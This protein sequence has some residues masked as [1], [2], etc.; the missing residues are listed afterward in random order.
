MNSAETLGEQAI[1]LLG[2]LV[3][4]ACVNNGEP[5]SGQEIRNADVLSRFFAGSGVIPE[6]VE[7][8]PGRASLVVRIP[9]TLPGALSLAL[10][11][12]I[13]VVPALAAD[14]TVDPF[15]AE[16]IDDVLFGRGSLDM[17]YLTA[18]YAVLARALAVES[19]RPNGTRLRGDLIFAAVADEEAGSRLGVEWL[20]AN[21]PDL[22]DADYVLT[23][24]GGVPVGG[25]AALGSE[26]PRQVSAVTVTVGEKG[27]ARRRLVVH[28]V[29]G[30]GSAP[31]GSRNAAVLAA[32]AVIRIT[33]FAPPVEI[34]D[35]W[36]RYVHALGLP[37]DLGARLIAPN[38]FEVALAELGDLAGYAHAATHT[39]LSPNVVRGG[40]AINVI[41]GLATVDL[42][43]RILPGVSVQDVD[44]YLRDA[45]GELVEHIE[46]TGTAFS[47]ANVS[48]MDNDL[49]EV[50]SEVIGETYPGARAL[51]IIAAGGS[52]ARF[53]RARG[54]TAF[55]FSMLSE[56]WTYGMFRTLIHSNDE[57]IDLPSVRLTV[58]TLERVVRRLL[59]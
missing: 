58:E 43:V 15:S 17:L 36:P 18:S 45:L 29:P 47:P 26:E 24:S 54:R 9:G 34:G 42:D 1:A 37:A 8:H 44:R 22:V 13:D 10:V 7:P 11:G 2:D 21:R 6:I 28:G 30:H 23:E 14:W 5:D 33:Q 56:R 59:G 39:T 16:I 19:Q 55:G 51:P 57:S 46:I 20:L 25:E 41:P 27:L 53:Y 52:D 50:L 31:W 35:Y 48:S 3:R 49:F 12:H 4:S 40:D 32:E 38:T